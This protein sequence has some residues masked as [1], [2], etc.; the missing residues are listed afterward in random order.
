M[1]GKLMVKDDALQML[2]KAYCP[3]LGLNELEDY[4]GKVIKRA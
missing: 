1:D 2:L 3:Q 4:I